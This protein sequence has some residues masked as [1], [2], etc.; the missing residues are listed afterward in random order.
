VEQGSCH[1]AYNMNDVNIPE[2]NLNDTQVLPLTQG[3][4]AK[5]GAKNEFGLIQGYL[6][7][8]FSY[9]QTP[10]PYI[11]NYFDINHDQLVCDSWSNAV[12]H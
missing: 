7:L 1:S 11:W 4:S 8:P 2:Q 10:M 9:S 6:T 12:L 5:V 3:F